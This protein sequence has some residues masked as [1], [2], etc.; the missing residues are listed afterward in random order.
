L[1]TTRLLALIDGRAVT[2]S[3]RRCRPWVEALEG[4]SLLTTLTAIGTNL[5]VTAG[6]GFKSQV[7]SFTT[8]DLTEKASNYKVT[9]KWGDSTSATGVVTAKGKTHGNFIVTGS[10]N[11]SKNGLP[12]DA[13][14]VIVRDTKKGA[15]DTATVTTNVTVKGEAIGNIVTMPVQTMEGVQLTDQIVA[16]F[17]ASY[18]GA[19]ESDFS[20]KVDFRDFLGSSGEMPGAAN[21]V[22]APGSKGEFDVEITHEF[23]LETNKQFNTV[24]G[25]VLGPPSIA[26]TVEDN[27]LPRTKGASYSF[28]VY[29]PIQIDDAPLVASGTPTTFNATFGQD[30]GLI[31]I[32]SFMDMNMLGDLH[33]YHATIDWGDDTPATMIMGTTPGVGPFLGTPDDVSI[34]ADHKYQKTGSFPVTIEV[35]DAGDS[36]LVLHSTAKVAGG[37]TL[38]GVPEMFFLYRTPPPSSPVNHPTGPPTRDAI[39]DLAYFGAPNGTQLSDYTITVNYGDGFIDTNPELAS[40]NSPGFAP[41]VAIVANHTYATGGPIGFPIDKMITVTVTGPGIDS[42]MPLT[43]TTKAIIFQDND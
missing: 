19:K 28:V 4:R 39:D 5:N 33:E 7:A 10:H 32:G 37:G 30:T 42:S 35:G 9:I 31:S 26:I 12:S 43:S 11:Y 13:V 6:Q 22:P 34:V 16:T 23:R 36:T 41:Y 24:G 14:T 2:I 21:I 25:T 29:P 40:L 15:T 27:A 8:S 3:G 17:R 1:D 18:K 20:S 38:Q